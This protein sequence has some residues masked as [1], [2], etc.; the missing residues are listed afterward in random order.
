M[1]FEARLMVKITF[2]LSRL[3]PESR[4]L[5]LEFP[6]FQGN[7]VVHENHGL[8]PSTRNDGMLEYW[9]SGYQK[10]KQH[11]YCSSSSQPI[12]PVF[13]YSNIP[14][15]AKSLNSYGTNRLQKYR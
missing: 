6:E 3:F 8:M 14:V 2:N 7:T 1:R 5:L 9:N 15:A 11:I 13:H 4:E 10:W 12:V